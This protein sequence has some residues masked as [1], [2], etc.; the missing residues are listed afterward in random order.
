MS[1]PLGWA[2]HRARRH[3]LA[4][5]RDVAEEQRCL[6]SVPGER[7]PAWVLGHLVLA[8]VYLLSV[9]GAEPL[10]EDFPALLRAYGPG[11]EPR[12]ANG[13]YEPIRALEARLARTGSVRRAVIERMSPGE[14]DRPNPD[15]VLARNQPTIGHHLHA[16]LFHE[17]HH[18]GQLAAW[19]R[20]HGL[21]AIPWTFASDAP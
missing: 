20:S 3:T 5:V 21:P 10:P 19:R 13:L 1:E 11:A 16:L 7:H 2:L 15:A 9:L 14:L 6:Q 12:G 17:G 8:D 4:L 18:A